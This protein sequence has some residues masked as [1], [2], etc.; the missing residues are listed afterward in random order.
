MPFLERNAPLIRT[1]VG[2]NLRQMINTMIWQAQ[3]H[4]LGVDDPPKHLQTGCPAGI[5]LLELLNGSWFLAVFSVG[6][7]QGA[8]D[9]VKGTKEDTADAL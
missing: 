5:A 4:G 3:R 2:Q 9:V 6:V 1:D 8:E 7:V